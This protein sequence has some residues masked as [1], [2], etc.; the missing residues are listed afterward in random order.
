MN[1]SPG[2]VLASGSNRYLMALAAKVRS[3]LRTW[4]RETLPRLATGRRTRVPVKALRPRTSALR[5]VLEAAGLFGVLPF[6]GLIVR[7]SPFDRLSFT[8]TRQQPTDNRRTPAEAHKP[9][10]RASA[11]VAHNPFY[12][13][14]IFYSDY[15][16]TVRSPLI[17][18]GCV[19]L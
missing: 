12:V 18:S 17:K 1:T 14:R 15:L 5:F 16:W 2:A 9:S 3:A 6:I 4:R 7:V 19:P 8:E 10:G 11:R 13:K